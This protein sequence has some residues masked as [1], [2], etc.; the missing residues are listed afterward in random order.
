MGNSAAA[1]TTLLEQMLAKQ[2]SYL[3]NNLRDG[4]DGN[5]SAGQVN[6][7]S[8]GNSF[9]DEIYDGEGVYDDAT[10]AGQLPL[11]SK[12][13]GD[14]YFN[15]MAI[16]DDDDEA[17]G[18]PLLADSYANHVTKQQYGGVVDN[19]NDDDGDD[20][21]DD[22]LIFIKKQP[23]VEP[24]FADYNTNFT[25]EYHTPKYKKQRTISLPQLPH[26]KLNYDA[27]LE[28]PPRVQTQEELLHLTGSSA[29][30]LEG[31]R[32]V[33]LKVCHS[34]SPQPTSQPPVTRTQKRLSANSK[35]FATDKDG[36]YIYRRDDVFGS[37]GR[38]V[39]VDLLGQGTFGKVLKC[40]DNAANAYVAVKIIRSVDRYR[41]AAKTEL[42]V[43]AQIMQNDPFGKFQCLLLTDFF[44]YKDHICLVSP[45]YGRSIY[46]FM[47]SNGVARFPGS[48]IQAI[49]RQLIRSV[50]FLHDLGII[51]TDIKPEN[52]LICD[53]SYN[54]YDLPDDI[55][56]SLSNR[57]RIASGGKRKILKDPEIK[58]IDFGSAVFHD[59]YHPPVISTRHYRAPEIVFGLGWSYPC[60]I[61]SLACVLI[62]L[63]IGE[64]LYPIHENFEHLAMMQ[65]INGVAFPVEMVDKMF[66]KYKN[67]LG[68][69]PGDLYTTVLKHFNKRTGQLMWPEVNKNG[70][71][72]TTLKSIKRVTDSSERLDIMVSKFLKRDY[73]NEKFSI[74]WNLTPD[75][76]WSQVKGTF[77]VRNSIGKETF[78]FWY[79]FV[80]LMR[81]MFEFDPTKRITAREALEH[82]W[83]NLGI[84]D[85]GITNFNSTPVTS[86]Y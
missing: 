61:W 28:L 47:C 37:N 59:E 64:S 16:V 55:V 82:E 75:Q 34:L 54:E 3:N 43:L 31:N 29:K 7:P 86:S 35:Y 57:R 44:D 40:F 72:V 74:N 70:E 58:I 36:H 8:A 49:A 6:L 85:D 41:E 77:G 52:I 67:K 51:H 12:I 81:L 66:F 23:A 20:D 46:D 26:A 65:R 15:E 63:A 60:D 83:F 13:N 14:R 76:N 21:D 11:K 24:F 53:E 5:V 68:N 69:L 33:N 39:S 32:G 18:H 9:L 45:L 56:N 22:D 42:R 19:D 38:F 84:W 30:T 73:Q 25:T 10:T 17:G 1:T 78:L 48:H 2:N 71:T 80:D 27:L 4:N 79:W 50:S 62:E